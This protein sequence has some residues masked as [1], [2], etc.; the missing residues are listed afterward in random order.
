MP[1]YTP[2]FDYTENIFDD[3]I[4]SIFALTIFEALLHATA[5]LVLSIMEE[6]EWTLQTIFVLVDQ[7]GDDAIFSNTLEAFTKL[8]RCHILWGSAAKK[9]IIAL[10]VLSLMNSV[11]ALA[12]MVQIAI[13]DG[14]L[15]LSSD[16]QFSTEP[17]VIIVAF[18][19]LSV[20]LCTN[21][22][23][24]SMIARSTQLSVGSLKLQNDNRLND[25]VAII[26]IYWH[27]ADLNQDPYILLL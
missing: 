1:T 21:I 20:N 5:S 26:K 24:T 19:F 18:V 6:K 3:N 7:M 13:G 15:F 2:I 27:W 22:I 12:A 17:T 8:Y 25:I 10:V 23:L 16:S 14:L 11:A 9:I 4:E